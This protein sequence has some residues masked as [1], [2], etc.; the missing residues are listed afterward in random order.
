MTLDGLCGPSQC[1]QRLPH[2]APTLCES[3]IHFDFHAT[4]W[5]AALPHRNASLQVLHC[6]GRIAEIETHGRGVALEITEVIQHLGVGIAS[7]CQPMEYGESF[8]IA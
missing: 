7:L 3:R 8:V 4:R 5:V 1:H 2:D 6:C